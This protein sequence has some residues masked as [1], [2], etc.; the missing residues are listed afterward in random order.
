MHNTEEANCADRVAESL[1]EARFE[2]QVLVRLIKEQHERQNNRAHEEARHPNDVPEVIHVNVAA[3]ARIHHVERE[4]D[5]LRFAD[6][7]REHL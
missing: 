1:A 6:E 2:V 4:H 5:N 3:E 7:E